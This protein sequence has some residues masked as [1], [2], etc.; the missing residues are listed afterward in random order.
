MVLANKRAPLELSVLEIFQ[1]QAAAEKNI[2][3]CKGTHLS[4][5]LVLLS[6]PLSRF[7][8][9]NS[10]R[11]LLGTLGSNHARLF[12]GRRRRHLLRRRCR[13]CRGGLLSR[14]RG[15][16]RLRV[17]DGCGN[18]GHCCGGH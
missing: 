10:V 14:D 12:R 3:G 11:F 4:Q 18:G 15:L 6:P 1:Q 16:R 13:L 7:P 8:A 17:G 5:K 9:V 2:G